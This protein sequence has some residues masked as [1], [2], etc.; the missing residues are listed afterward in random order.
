MFNKSQ[1]SN[2]AAPDYHPEI[3]TSKLLEGDEVTLYQSYIGILCWAVELQCMDIV[4]ATAT[5]A[6]FMS[7]P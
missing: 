2:P 7:A 3:D 5:M 1:L 6:K 4:H